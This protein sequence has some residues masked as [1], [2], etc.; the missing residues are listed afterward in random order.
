M[1]K[2][3]ERRIKKEYKNTF[4]MMSMFIILVV[5]MVSCVYTYVKTHQIVHFKYVQF[6][7]HKLYFDKT[8]NEQDYW[9]STIIISIL[10]IQILS[11][12]GI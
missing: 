4:W 2:E 12:K 8:I 11:Q 1:G 6:I 7:V 5:V 3:Q 9:L 10:Q